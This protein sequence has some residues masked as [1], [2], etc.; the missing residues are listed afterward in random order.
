[1]SASENNKRIAKNTL[2]LYIR[3]LLSIAVS[4]YTS[5]VV[6]N[7]LGVEDYGIYGVV[8]GVVSMFSFLNASMSGATSRFLT[9]EMAGRN[10]LRL[11]ETFSSALI[12]HIGIALAILIFA[13][14]IGLWFLLNKLVIPENRMYAACWVYQL[15]VFSMI[16]GVTQVP[17]NASIIANEK[18]D[19]Y[20]YVEIVN[21]ILKLLIVYLLVI[22][23]FDKLILYAVLTLIVS[24]IIAFIY[25]IYCI[26]YFQECTFRW[27]WRTEILKPMLSFSGWD[28]YGNMCVTIR[29]QGINIFQNIFFGAKINAAVG[30]ATTVQGILSGLANNV[31]M[32][33]RPQIIKKYAEGN[34]LAMEDLMSQTLKYTLALFMIMSIPLYFEVDYVLHLWLGVVPL[35]TSNFFRL[36]LIGSIVELIN[37]V[38]VIAIHATGQIKALSFITGTWYLIFLLPVYIFFIEGFSPQSAYWMVIMSNIFVVCTDCVI[39]KRTIKN[40]NLKR[41]LFVNFLGNILILLVISIVIYWIHKE[42]SEG[43]LRVLSVTLSVVVIYVFLFYGIMLTQIERKNINMKLRKKVKL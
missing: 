19:V 2:I 43:L 13:E 26:K 32:A 37:R 11:K 6:L 3:M 31:I 21:V 7:T 1:M 16:V 4:L 39:L 33:F 5:R 22:G 30:T 38:I 17:Y 20:A 8:G 28:L 24:V 42:Q 23:N 41:I 35:Y 40:I 36:I 9:F 10:S 29:Q 25:R 34:I 12:V 15:S 14:T 27:V 18:M